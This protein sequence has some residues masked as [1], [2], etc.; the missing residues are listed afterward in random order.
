MGGFVTGPGGVAAWLLGKPLLIHEQNA[1]AGLSNQLLSPL[2][3]VVMEGFAG[4]FKRKQA[5][6]KSGLIRF[7]TEKAVHIGNPLRK[8]VLDCEPPEKRFAGRQDQRIRLL[9]IGGSLGAQAINRFL[10]EF[11]AQYA[12]I[13]KLQLWHQCGKNNLHDSLQAYEKAGIA[14]D[15]INVEPFIDNMAQAYAWADVVLCRAG[16]STVS[17]IAAVGIPAVFVPFPYA[18]DNHQTENALILQKLGAAWIIQQNEL[19]TQKLANILDR[20]LADR[21]LILRMALLAKEAG[22]PQATQTA[23]AYCIEACYV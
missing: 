2:A 23:A 8:E 1:I 11:L 16:A 21:A 22:K 15:E 5:L 10:P 19:S 12:N 6:S 9:I 13:D 18:V 3:T 4:A 14:T 17:E 7:D 20:F